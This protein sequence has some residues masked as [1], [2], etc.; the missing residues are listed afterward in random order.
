VAI[1]V[2]WRV[3]ERQGVK[4][5]PRYQREL[6]GVTRMGALTPSVSMTEE[7]LIPRWIE[8][9]G[10]WKNITS[11][12]SMSASSPNWH[13]QVKMANPAQ[14]ALATVPPKVVLEAKIEPSL[15]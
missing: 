1:V 5:T 11:I 3:Q 9:W 8:G 15:T 10:R 4:K 14:A 12:L 2:M 7:G 6:A 13:S